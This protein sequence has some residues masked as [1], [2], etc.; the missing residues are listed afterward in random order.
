MDTL[1]YLKRQRE[2]V[3]RAEERKQGRKGY[4]RSHSLVGVGLAHV[5]G[6]I[7]AKAK[8]GKTQRCRGLG[9]GKELKREGE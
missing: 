5:C 8:D 3:S 6:S 1:P 2:R 4:K 9:S 7:K